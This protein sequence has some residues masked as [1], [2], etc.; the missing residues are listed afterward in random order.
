MLY[1]SFHLPVRSQRGDHAAA[2]THR[3]S[4]QWPRAP[5]SESP[6]RVCFRGIP[7]I[8]PWNSLFLF[9]FSF[10]VGSFITVP[11]SSYLAPLSLVPT[12]S[13]SNTHT[14]IYTTSLSHQY[15]HTV[16]Y[17]IV[18]RPFRKKVLFASR[19]LLSI[20]RSSIRPRRPACLRL[21]PIPHPL[22]ATGH[23]S[24]PSFIFLP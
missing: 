15:L 9:Y 23:N 1:F 13:P 5:L 12:L 14:Y 2:Y 22:L 19:I 8:R 11:P 21:L 4:S 18:A 17:W 6:G 10:F 16:V 20:Y 7:A 3:L 24:L